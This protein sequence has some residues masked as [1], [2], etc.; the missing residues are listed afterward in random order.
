MWKLSVI[1][2]ITLISIISQAIIVTILEAF[3][4]YFHVNFVIQY[5]LNS[6]GE[7][8][9]EADLIYHSI[10]IFSLFFQVLLVVDAL[11]H[12]NSV[13]IVA[14]VIFNLLSLAY[15]GLQLYQHEILE[16]KGTQNA[17]YAPINPIF[18]KDNRDAPKF[19][20]EARMRP[21]EYTIIGLISAFP[22]YLSFMSYK[23]T[24]EFGWENY[25][26]YSAD[27]R[28]RDAV[29]SL[30]ILQAL[31][32]L[33]IFFIGSYALQL[34]PSPKIGYYSTVVEIALVFF[35]GTLM[36]LIALF[37][38]IMEKKYL[39]LSAI[40]LYSISLIYWAYRLITINLPVSD[41]DATTFVLV[42][43]TVI[44]SIICF[45]N[46]SRG[47]YVLAVYGRHEDEAEDFNRNQYS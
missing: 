20:Y 12:R 44:Y 39:L 34:I 3:V 9:S 42:L 5:K 7:G 16:D 43:I 15:A 32:K 31:I 22:I 4:I 47:I 10:F 6:V 36:L 2:K 41:G 14:L 1:G 23:L 18:P 33:D 11:W 21:I 29:W 8:I 13:E 37:S 38:V 17:T 26:I 28:V 19:Y 40:N 25:K 45:R 30:K 35:L 24:K 46:M 27:I